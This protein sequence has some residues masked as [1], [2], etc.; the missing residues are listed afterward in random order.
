LATPTARRAA[1]S[2]ST[3]TCRR[4]GKIAGSAIRQSR[5]RTTK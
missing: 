5:P 3:N 2:S 4:A 1:I